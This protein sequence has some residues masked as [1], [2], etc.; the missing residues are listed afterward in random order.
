[1][2]NTLFILAI[3]ALFYTTSVESLLLTFTKQSFHGTLCLLRVALVQLQVVLRDKDCVQL[4]A[5]AQENWPASCGCLAL[6]HTESAEDEEFDHGS[7]G[8]DHLD[9]GELWEAE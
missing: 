2:R 4:E 8:V 7:S 9:C 5:P 6:Q 1:M 3:G